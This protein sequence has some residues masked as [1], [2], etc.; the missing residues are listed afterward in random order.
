M[1]TSRSLKRRR[2]FDKET[3]SKT[4]SRPFKSP[5]RTRSTQHEENLGD[6]QSSELILPN[7]AGDPQSSIN[8]EVGLCGFI[9]GVSH[10]GSH[11]PEIGLS[12]GLIL[13]GDLFLISIQDSTKPQSSSISAFVSVARDDHSTA[14]LSSS[15]H[16]RSILSITSRPFLGKS[17]PAAV[18]DGLSR[19]SRVPRDP[20]V[21][22]L[23]QH[24]QQLQRCLATLRAELDMVKQAIRIEGI[25]S[26]TISP[27]GPTNEKS[28][29]DEELEVLIT[30]W[31]NASQNAADELFTF[32]S[33]KVRAMGGVATWKDKMKASRGVSGT[34]NDDSEERDPQYSVDQRDFD[35]Q[36]SRNQTISK[37]R[38]SESAEEHHELSEVSY[39]M[40]HAFFPFLF[41]YL[42][43]PMRISP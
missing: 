32:A 16:G 43:P 13:I 25:A 21:A 26:T 34:W 6:H 22:E 7:G 40:T 27:T 17:P 8:Y 31:R 3:V 38:N 24:Q 30:K 18:S 4:L 10:R 2:P 29:R 14:S 33:E 41:S 28:S 5:L 19:A 39:R 9:H 11:Q 42:L 36:T 15:R 23:Q 37:I 1:D 20:D 12:D 35:Y